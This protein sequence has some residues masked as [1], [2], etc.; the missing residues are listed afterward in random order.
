MRCTSNV[1]LADALHR[2]AVKEDAPLAS[3]LADGLERLDGAD[4]VVGQHHANKDRL[5]GDRSLHVIGVDAAV[6]A[7][8]EVGDVEALLFEALAS[9]EHGLVLGHGRDDVI[10]LVA[11]ELAPRL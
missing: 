3:D 2:V 7:H 1:D 10:A 4:F 9:V 6:G 11:M 5:V 8:A